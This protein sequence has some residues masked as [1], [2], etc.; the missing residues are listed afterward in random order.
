MLFT[1]L[2]AINSISFNP[3]QQSYEEG[4]I[5]AEVL[6]GKKPKLGGVKEFV[7]SYITRKW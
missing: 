4:A 6:Q 2:S 7:C 5:I 1:G 3:S